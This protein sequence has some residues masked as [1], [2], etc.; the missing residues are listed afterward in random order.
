VFI[1]PPQLFAPS[2]RIGQQQAG[3]EKPLPGLSCT[4][5]VDDSEELIGVGSLDCVDRPLID[6]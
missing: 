5:A 4:V 2:Y 6:H 1:D 3:F